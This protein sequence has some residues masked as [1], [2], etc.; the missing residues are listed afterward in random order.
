[1]SRSR[2]IN[3]DR[4]HFDIP[5]A[6]FT[7]GWFEENCDFRQRAAKLKLLMI[8]ELANWGNTSDNEDC[9]SLAD[10]SRGF[11]LRYQRLNARLIILYPKYIEKLDVSVC[12]IISA[13]LEHSFACVALLRSRLSLATISNVKTLL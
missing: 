8:K 5:K 1:M 9:R 13:P 7:N 6:Y 10:K 2:Q 12:E 11:A 3:R 4:I